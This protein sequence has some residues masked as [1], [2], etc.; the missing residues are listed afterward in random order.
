MSS[1]KK[2]IPQLDTL[3]P[4]LEEIYKDLHRHPELSMSEFRTA[5]IAAD[6]LERYGYEVTREIGVTGVVGVLHNGEGPVVM[7]RADM[8]AL[9]MAEATGLPY[10]A[11][12]VTRNAEGVEVPVCHSCG[13][14]MHVTWLMGVARV[15]AEHRDSW[16]GTLLAVFQPGEEVGI[17]AQS[18]VDDGM[19]QRFPKPDI[20]LGQH[21]MVGPAGTVGHRSG[22]ILS[23]GDSLKVKLFGQGSHGSQPQ[24]SID[25]V[26]MAAS[27]VLRL[28]TIVSREISPSDQA[29]LTVGSLQA[30]TKENII[31]D[32]ATLKLNMRTYDEGVREHMLGAI[33]RICCAECAASNAPREPEFT[34]LN[35][36]PLTINDA[37]ASIRLAQAFGD[38]FGDR[39]YE[40]APAAASEDFSVFGRAWQVPYVFWFVGC[41]DPQIYAQAKAKGAINSIASN[42]SPKFAPLL[43]PTLRTGLETMLCA[44]FA[45]FANAE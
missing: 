34:T 42:H 9:P 11:D 23:A 44:A 3:L 26:V 30:G 2:L 32:D 1:L 28:Q 16:Q 18:M 41:T 5:K 19:L 40:T 17:G 14:D 8:D 27:T 21:V 36:Y 22:T 37:N 10:A 12:V 39:A 29:V 45:W 13:H 25:P 43:H 31:P 33:K 20:I 15:L 38:W 24:T 7:L 4:E 35:R 6:Y